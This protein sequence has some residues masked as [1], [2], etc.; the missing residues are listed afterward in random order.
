MVPTSVPIMRAA[1]SRD[2][3]SASGI[4]LRTGLGGRDPTDSERS[5]DCDG[6]LCRLRLRKTEETAATTGVLDALRD[7]LLPWLS[8]DIVR[9]RGARLLVEEL[10][11]SKLPGA[12]DAGV[13]FFSSFTRGLGTFGALR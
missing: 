3:D 10:A 11:E 4:R 6:D 8:P 2:E 7:D 9:W 12:D 13:F 5:E 1:L